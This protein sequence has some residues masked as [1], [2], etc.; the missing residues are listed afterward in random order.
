[1]RELSHVW[2]RVK[3]TEQARAE[4]LER[5]LNYHQRNGTP[6][7]RQLYGSSEPNGTCKITASIWTMAIGSF[8]RVGTTG[9]FLAEAPATGSRSSYEA[10]QFDVMRILGVLMDSSAIAVLAVDHRVAAGKQKLAAAKHHLSK[11][12][13]AVPCESG[14]TIR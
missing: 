1:M 13:E 2:L 6:Q 4:E 9:S 10:E 8:T 14:S 12:S 5:E 11:R 3:S 7:L